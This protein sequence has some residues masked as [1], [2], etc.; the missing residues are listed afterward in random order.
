MIPKLTT[1]LEKLPG[2]VH[3]VSGIACIALI[4]LIFMPPKPPT[5]PS[6]ITTLEDPPSFSR[7]IR[8]LA[9]N[10]NY[11]IIFMVHGLNIGLSVAF[12]SIFTQIISPYGYTDIQ[13]GQMNAVGFFAGT[14]G[15][16][17]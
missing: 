15:C 14:L 10:Y 17:K 3:I 1:S 13:A 11:W 6:S 4:P 8:L 5:P 7:D 2:V 16:C 9:K 12:G